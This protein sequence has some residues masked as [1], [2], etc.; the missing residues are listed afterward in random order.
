MCCFKH[1]DGVI[2]NYY[3]EQKLLDE[4]KLSF[5]TGKLHETW[6]EA[7]FL[8]LESEINPGVVAFNRRRPDQVKKAQHE[9]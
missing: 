9:G 8:G 1:F 6:Q 4:T 7:F 2:S 3:R 5:E